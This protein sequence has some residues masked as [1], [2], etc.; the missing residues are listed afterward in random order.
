MVALHHQIADICRIAVEANADDSK[1]PDNWLF[2]HRWV[3][4]FA[5]LVRQDIIADTTNLG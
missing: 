5:P 1:F 3:R 2:R 4:C